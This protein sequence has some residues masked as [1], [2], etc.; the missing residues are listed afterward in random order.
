LP[1]FFFDYE[2]RC[3]SQGNI[4][5]KY[6]KVESGKENVRKERVVG[7]GLRKNFITLRL[8]EFQLPA[9]TAGSSPTH[10]K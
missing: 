3:L 8:A 7:V 10:P 5:R 2:V 9:M 4:K 1:L 6:L